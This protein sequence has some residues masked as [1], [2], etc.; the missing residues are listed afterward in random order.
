MTDLFISYS[1]RDLD[2]VQQLYDRL[3]ARERDI[4]IDLEDIP[5]TAEWLQ[6]IYTGIEAANAFVFV[7]SPHSAVSEVCR[8]EIEHAVK[9]NKKLVPILREV[10][11]DRTLLHGSLASHNWLFFRPQDEFERAFKLLNDALDTDLS[12][13]RFHTRLLVRA[14]EWE[15]RKRDTSFLLRGTDLSDAEQWLGESM[16]K[17]PIPTQLHT[18]Y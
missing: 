16:G 12:Y 11:P 18:Q 4:W 1:R 13:V 6:E 8:L 2:F 7:I 3:K 17:Q 15:N 9:H 14:L 5:P 10:V